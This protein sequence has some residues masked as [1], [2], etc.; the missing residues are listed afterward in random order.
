MRH[1]ADFE[2]FRHFG[3]KK[4]PKKGFEGVDKVD[5]LRRNQDFDEEDRGKNRRVPSA[6][7]LETCCFPRRKSIPPADSMRETLRFP[8]PSAVLAIKKAR[9]RAFSFNYKEAFTFSNSS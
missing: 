1:P 5:T 7:C 3:I 2:P 6:K 4:S 8:H 9:K